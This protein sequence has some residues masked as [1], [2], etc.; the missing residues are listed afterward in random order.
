MA[1]K[2]QLTKS[3]K[4]QNL[5][6]SIPLQKTQS[7]A[8]L[9]LQAAAFLQAAVQTPSPNHDSLHPCAQN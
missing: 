5:Y 7:G 2:K 1:I 9:S 8:S 6:N 4:T 3:Y